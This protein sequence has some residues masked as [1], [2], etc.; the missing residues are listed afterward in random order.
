MT[1]KHPT[2]AWAQR[3]QHIYLSVEVDDMKIESLT[4]DDDSFKIKGTKGSDVYEADLQLFAKLVG[5][6]RRQIATDRRVE[7]VIPKAVPEWWPR[8]IKDKGKV[9][10]I[11]VDFDKWK[12]EDD[13]KEEED[14]GG[15]GGMGGMEGMDFSQFGMPGGAGGFMNMGGKGGKPDG[16]FNMDDLD[17]GDDDIGDGDDEEPGDLEDIDEGSPDKGKPQEGDEKSNG[18]PTKNQK[19]SP[20]TDAKEAEKIDD[21]TADLS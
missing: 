18:S 17:L 2:I 16:G 21:S 6:E 9:P 11:K 4:V 8:L 5:S 19:S 14:G 12:D 20:S 13:E 15:F 3:S 1:V 7:L 10:W